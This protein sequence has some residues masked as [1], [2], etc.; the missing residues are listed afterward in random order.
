MAGTKDQKKK[1]KRNERKKSFIM[2]PVIWGAENR[3]AVGGRTA[4]IGS[5]EP[6]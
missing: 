2:C 1:K 3:N 5:R 6:R 4:G